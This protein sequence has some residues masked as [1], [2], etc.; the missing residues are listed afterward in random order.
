MPVTVSVF[1]G[2]VGTYSFWSDG[3]MKI[4]GDALGWK[5]WLDIGDRLP[6]KMVCVRL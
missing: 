4:V 3:R 6:M 2:V 1:V 5:R